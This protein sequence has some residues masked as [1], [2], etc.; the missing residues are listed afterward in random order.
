M[1][2]SIVAVN[3]TSM[4]SLIRNYRIITEIHVLSTWLYFLTNKQKK[5]RKIKP[6]FLL[7][8]YFCHWQSCIQGIGTSLAVKFDPRWWRKSL[9]GYQWFV[10]LC[11]ISVL[12]FVKNY[13]C[14][15]IILLIYPNE[16]IFFLSMLGLGL[17]P[18]CTRYQQVRQNKKQNCNICST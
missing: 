10:I 6:A 4:I 8:S 12:L 14:F 2:V 1:N 11:F 7:G 18:T 17:G 16:K 9:E 13:V 3:I 15:I 5:F